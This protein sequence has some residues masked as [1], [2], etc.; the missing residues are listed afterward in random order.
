MNTRRGLLSSTRYS[1]VIASVLLLL[2]SFPCCL[3]QTDDN[4]LA[5]G[6]W[7]EI[8]NDSDDHAVY[9]LR[10]RLL[11]YD[12]QGPSS[13]NHARVY[14]ELQNVFINGWS[15]PLEVYFKVG[16]YPANKSSLSFEMR[17][18]QG[19]PVPTKPTVI[20]GPMPDPY[21][22]ILPCEST[23]RLRSDIYLLGQKEKPDHLDVFVNGGEWAIRPNATNEY[24]LSA[25][26]SVTD[27]P[28]SSLKNHIWEGT[29]HLPAVKIPVKKP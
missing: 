1:V 15:R 10:G 21:D 12:D 22:V 27:P 26:L 25:T 29:L 13:A 4:L 5:T 7:S 11:V 24:F 14:V 8:V 9:A 20:R 18:A 16:L 6:A 23:I 2:A 19:K 28:A 17:D 3:G